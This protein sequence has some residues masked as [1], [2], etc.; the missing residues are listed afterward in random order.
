M[1]KSITF[2]LPA[3]AIEGASEA[4]L[5][6]DFND[7]NPEKA[8]KLERQPDGSFAA[9]AHLEVGRTYHYRFL[10]ND[11]RWVNDYNAQ[12][13]QNAPGLYVD[14]CVITISESGEEENKKEQSSEKQGESSKNSKPK[15]SKIKAAS[16]KP[17]AVKTKTPRKSASKSEGPKSQKSKALNAK[18]VGDKPEKPAKPAKTATQKK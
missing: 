2:T 9:V 16:E 6:G 11:G 1:T 12:S 8:Q 5:L 13:Y 10:L 4:I 3:E 7:W 18:I 15:S 14:N 17:G